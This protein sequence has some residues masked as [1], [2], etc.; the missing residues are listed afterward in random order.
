MARTKKSAG[1]RKAS[2]S[3][4]GKSSFDTLHGLF[5]LKLQSLYDV[6][7]ELV[8]VLPKLAKNSSDEELQMAFKEHLKETEGHVR[9]LE[10]AFKI[11]G[12]KPKKEKVEAIRGIAEDG[13]WVMKN[14]RDEAARDAALIGAAQYAEHYEIAGYGTACEWADLMGHTEV[15]DLLKQ[16]LEEEEAA[17]EKLS[18]L[19]EGGINEEA[20]DMSEME[21]RD[22][23]K[24]GVI[25]TWM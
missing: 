9:R 16:T 17:D 6:E 14:V 15:A 25:G 8:K 4:S 18:S 2:G 1:S 19:A 5:I 20:N 11:L 21:E 23:A 22:T 13:S 3:T 24:R 10:K 7:Q 12:V